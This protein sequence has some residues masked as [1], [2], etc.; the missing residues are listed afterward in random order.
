MQSHDP[1]LADA[2]AG[3]VRGEASALQ[4]LLASPAQDVLSAALD[5]GVLAFVAEALASGVPAGVADQP[6]SDDTAALVQTHARQRAIEDL[7]RQG[8]LTRALASLCASGVSPLMI[9]G[10]QL[11]YTHYPRP[12]LRPR[13]DDDLLI[14]PDA[15]SALDDVLTRLAYKRQGGISGELVMSQAMYVK[16]VK[17]SPASAL[18]VHW[19]I[20]NAAVFARVLEY[21]ELAA[22]AVPIRALGPGARGLSPVHALLL[23]CVHRVAHHMDSER[24]IWLYDIHLL[25]KAMSPEEWRAFAE[26]AAAREIVAVCRR[27]LE[28]THARFPIVVPD[29][30]WAPPRWRD[31]PREELSARYLDARRPVSAIIDD[32]R[33]LPAW[34]DRWRLAR[35]HLVPSADYM[36]TVFAP[37]SRAPLAWLYVRRLVRGTRTWLTK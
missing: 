9:K 16:Q 3:V 25:A 5:H 20:A 24:L 15:R 37:G 17:G 30:V 7:F 36:R 23:A 33:A 11:A 35:E 12:H 28:R 14:S 18:D 31:E 29:V 26:L 2:L 34:R 27:S 32:L 1:L 4:H 10:G 13:V 19:R 6:R 21:D 8:E 22:A